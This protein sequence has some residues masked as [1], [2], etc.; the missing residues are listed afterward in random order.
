MNQSIYKMKTTCTS[1]QN[2]FDWIQF[3]FLSPVDFVLKDQREK[4]SDVEEKR[5]PHRE[6]MDVVPKPW[7]KDYVAGLEAMSQ[8]LHITT[9]CMLQ[10]L[11]F[12]HTKFG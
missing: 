9:P 3:F 5:P 7:H 1:Y 8:K 2:D 10:V 4:E 12:W 11:D 6:E